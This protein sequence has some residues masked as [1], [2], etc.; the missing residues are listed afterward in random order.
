MNQ[1]A[2]RFLCAMGISFVLLP[3]TRCDGQE[4]RLN[5]IQTIGTHN[6]YRLTP[7]PEILS[8]IRL[9]LPDAADAL[10]YSHLPIPQ[11][12]GELNIRQ[13]ELDIYADPEG[14]LFANPVGH[15]SLPKTPEN[16]ARHPNVDGEMDAPGMKVLHSPGFDYGSTVPTFVAA[17]RQIRRWSQS[18]PTHLP[19]LILVELKESAVGPVLVKP[20]AFDAALLDAVDAEIR[21]VFS[22]DEMLLPDGIRGDSETLRDA[23]MQTGW[24]TLQQSRGRVWFALDNEGTIRD[25]YLDGHES[26]RDRVMFASVPVDHPAAAFRKLNDP[27]G[28]FAEIQD[29]VRRGL[30]VRTRADSETREAR[31]GDTTRRD[32]ALQSG[33]QYISTDYPVADPRLTDYRVRLEGGAEYRSNPVASVSE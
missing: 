11:Q 25:R 7:P 9:A 27:V 28:S 33:A 14:G 13:L 3:T 4:L 18:N 16:A 2:W 6:S 26:L 1:L 24:P 19:I 5:Q 12:L 29:A 22:N 17:L 32:R 31:S 8:M 21:S 15:E 10:D 30:I 20:V 23:I